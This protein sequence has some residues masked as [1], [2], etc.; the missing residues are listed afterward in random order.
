MDIRSFFSAVIILFDFDVVDVRVTPIGLFV[1]TLLEVVVLVVVVELD[2][3]TPVVG[4]VLVASR[5][6]TFGSIFFVVVVRFVALADVVTLDDICL[7]AVSFTC[8][9]VI[10]LLV[11]AGADFTL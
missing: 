11:T 10:V 3:V 8:F 2:F 6:V 5:F 7:L 1:P 9:S 4:P